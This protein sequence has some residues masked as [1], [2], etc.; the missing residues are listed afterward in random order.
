MKIKL[1]SPKMSLRPMDSEFKR[2]MSPSL[3]LVT[4]AS[5]INKE[6]LVYIEDENI[7]KINFDDQ[8]DL[9]GIN[10]NVDTSK[11]AYEI[12][13]V[14]KQK[15]IK[16][17]LGGIHVSANPEE[18]IKF[19]DSVCIGEAEEIMST[20]ILDA[21]NNRL[22]KFYYNSSVSN[23][24]NIPLPNWSLIKKSKYLYTNII[25]S[26]RGCPFKCEFCY[27]SNKYVHHK[28]RNR[29][30]SS[31]LE[32]IHQMD[33]KQVMF[34]DDN[35]IG[36]PQHAKQL[37]HELKKL[38]L[39]WHAAVSTNIVKMPEVMDLMKESGCK[40][41]FIGFESINPKSLE[42]AN[43]KQNKVEL[44]EKLI[45][46]L[47]SRNIM[48]NASLVFGFDNDTPDVFKSTLDWLIKNKI[49]TM[50]SHILTPYPGTV[51]Y[52]RLLKEN[53]IIDF[54]TNHY[55]T[56]NVVFKP[57]NMTAEQLRDG[58]LWIY[59]QFY[60]IKNIIKRIPDNEMQKKPYLLFNLAYRKFGKFTSV[61]G[62]L[63]LMSSLGKLGRKLS[64][65]IE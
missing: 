7:Q 17:I 35:F 49:E 23:P 58:Y 48:I 55:N 65:N 30:I 24:E 44:Y 42:S 12:A 27:N 38:N 33:T 4:L 11:R 32:E 2:R 47:H 56:A 20:I 43:K 6:H 34:I 63:G 22:K 9:V 45:N 14:Y 46:E 41:L 3:S 1:I 25:C 53:R 39:T 21:Q 40:S 19:A 60:S 62:K 5:L 50:T 57:K 54:D 36:N 28:Y 64:Y 26:S 10:V 52:D 16:V 59:D 37:M 8:P 13:N 31:V 15:G 18:A 51:L 61:I 29:P